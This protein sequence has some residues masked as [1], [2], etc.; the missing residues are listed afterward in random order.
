[1]L[2]RFLEYLQLIQI[3]FLDFHVPTSSLS[4]VL[5]PD[6]P[7]PDAGYAAQPTGA[8]DP[9][10]NTEG[11]LLGF[12]EDL[13]VIQLD[14]FDLHF[15]LLHFSLMGTGHFDSMEPPF[16]HRSIIASQFCGCQCFLRVN[17]LQDCGSLGM[18]RP[19]SPL[20]VDVVR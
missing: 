18:Q 6:A 19:S 1:M 4:H 8:S 15:Y 10:E 2:F 14:F 5:I 20:P 13:K 17:R 7:I 12:I 3:G 9:A 11:V 16:L